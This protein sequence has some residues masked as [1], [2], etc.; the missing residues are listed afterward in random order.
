MLAGA[1]GCGA[2]LAPVPASATTSAT[3]APSL[4]PDRLGARAAL[5]LTA[6]FAASDGGVPEPVRRAVLR[7]PAGL[8]LD[9]PKLR[10]C[11][12]GRLEVQGPKVCPSASR[13]GTGAAV[14]EGVLGPKLVREDVALSAFLGPLDGKGNATFLVLGQGIA[15][16]AEQLLL[17]GAAQIDRPP[18]GERLAVDVPPI[19]LVPLGPA[20]SLRSISL[21]IGARQRAGANALIVPRRCP[22]GGFPFAAKLAYADGASGEAKASVPCP[23]TGHNHPRQG[24]KARTATLRAGAAARR[25]RA[26]TARRRRA[27]AARV[28]ALNESAHLRL[29]SRKGFTLNEQGSVRGT[30]SGTIYVHLKIVSSSRVSA[31]VSIYRP[32]GSITGYASASYRRGAQKGTFKGTLSLA[33]GTGVY[34]FAKGV[35]LSFS[36]TIQRSDYAIAVH[37]GGRA[38]L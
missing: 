20:A 24:H 13:L 3:I 14:T 7:L 33:R 34:R 11:G 27:R 36:G 26:H 2:L 35:G 18:Y 17:T 1:V 25:L 8:T 10:A 22:A 19:E 29:T 9:V 12:A 30:V 15:P 21:T 37:V 28:V 23:H 31:E 5:T 4:S 32:G 16:V 6:R 38:S